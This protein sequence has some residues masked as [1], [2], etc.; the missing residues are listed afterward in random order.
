M[1]SINKV[2]ID[3]DLLRRL[4]VGE[5]KSIPQVA[6]EIGASL[7]TVRSRLL[8]L[9]VLR[10]RA[11]GVRAAGRHG[12][13]GSGTRGKKRVFSES[14]KENISKSKLARADEFAAGVSIKPSGYVEY[15]RGPN[16]GRCVH[17]V[18]MEEAIGRRLEKDEVVHHIDHNRSNNDL[19]NLQLMSR[20]AHAALHAIE[21]HPT[22]KRGKDGKFE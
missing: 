19:S 10:C 7:S 17:V 12:L 22:R 16:K 20:A 11:D 3:E 13:L 4:Y 5:S 14:H 6:A 21:N 1:A 9:G 15:T 18:A 2:A 8:R